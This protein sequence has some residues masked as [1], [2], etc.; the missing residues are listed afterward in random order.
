MRGR[1][2]RRPGRKLAGPRRIVLPRTPTTWET[3]ATGYR[4]AHLHFSDALR[5]IATLALH[6]PGFT[7]PVGADD[8]G[9]LPYQD[10]GYALALS[11]YQ[12]L[13]G[14]SQVGVGDRGLGGSANLYLD[15]GTSVDAPAHY[16][17][18][19]GIAS[20]SSSYGFSHVTSGRFDLGFDGPNANL[21]MIGGGRLG[22]EGVQ[23]R[24]G[25]AYVAFGTSTG[26]STTRTRAVVVARTKFGKTR[27]L[28]TAGSGSFVDLT[29]ALQTLSQNRRAKLRL[30]LP[31]GGSTLRFEAATTS[32]T[33]VGDY[34][35][36]EASSDA[37]LV[38]RHASGGLSNEYG[39]E[40]TLSTG[41]RDYVG[42]RTKHYTGVVRGGHLFTNQQMTFGHLTTTAS[43]ASYTLSATGTTRDTRANAQ[44]AGG[45]TFG[46]STQWDFDDHLRLQV[47]HATNEDSA[48]VVLLRRSD[49]DAD[50]RYQPDQRGDGLVSHA[51]WARRL[52]DVGGRT[53]RELSWEYHAL[54]ARVEH[55]LAD[56]RSLAR[57]RLDV[58]PKRS[59][60]RDSGRDARTVARPR[61]R[62]DHL[63]RVAWG[64]LRCDL[65]A[66]DRSDRVRTLPR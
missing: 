27:V 37:E 38:L 29:S 3:S 18:F 22:L 17:S 7:E 30:E 13:V 9:V 47:A 41:T 63:L 39:F 6:E 43:L 60:R 28:V 56:R 46:L 36:N 10:V 26:D 19:V 54:R 42:S 2:C 20:A 1:C 48:G 35:E 52:G 24:V 34:V 32:K 51:S 21:G 65:S 44:D 23:S 58:R 66:G 59:I 12:M 14:G 57:T 53:L 49:P 31:V 25:N 15:Y 50:D 62:L 8:L 33:P 16:L 55:R 11:P 45:P 4:S 40:Q 5:L 61:R 64:A